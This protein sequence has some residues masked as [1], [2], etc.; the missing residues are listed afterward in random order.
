MLKPGDKVFTAYDIGLVM[1]IE[2][3]DVTP[4]TIRQVITSMDSETEYVIMNI[5]YHRKHLFT[6]VEFWSKIEE[7]CVERSMLAAEKLAQIESK[8]EEI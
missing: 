6:P 7:L 5:K 8:N 3:N 2:K 4:R 1:D